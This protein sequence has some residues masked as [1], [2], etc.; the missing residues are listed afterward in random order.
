M[1]LCDKEFQLAIEAVAHLIAT[2]RSSPEVAVCSRA[3]VT[4]DRP[5]LIHAR[6]RCISCAGRPLRS[7]HTPAE[8]RATGS[9]L[10]GGSSTQVLDREE[11]ASA[12]LFDANLPLG[13]MV[14]D[15]L[16]HRIGLSSCNQRLRRATAYPAA[17]VAAAGRI[18]TIER[19]DPWCVRT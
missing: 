17:C 16:H 15:N 1:M 13:W 5:N 12:G 2:M 10:G 9:Q 18:V 8:A 4:D 3:L 11:T 19:E 14:D 7:A 6:T